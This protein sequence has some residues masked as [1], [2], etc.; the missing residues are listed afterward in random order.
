MTLGHLLCVTLNAVAFISFVSLGPPLRS[1]SIKE[2]FKRSITL[3]RE[4]KKAVLSV[5]KDLE[6]WF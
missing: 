1:L 4:I 3:N 6:T 2:G 5:G